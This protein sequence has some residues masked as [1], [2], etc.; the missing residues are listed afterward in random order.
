M[1]YSSKFSTQLSSMAIVSDVLGFKSVANGS[2][3]YTISIWSDSIAFQ[4]RFSS[5]LVKE[6]YRY[7]KVVSNEVN[8]SNGYVHIAFDHINFEAVEDGTDQQEVLVRFK[9]ILT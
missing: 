6:I 1:N 3:V 9:V 5:D 4:G 8:E 7:F 2:S